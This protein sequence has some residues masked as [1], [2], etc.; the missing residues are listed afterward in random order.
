M[1][2]DQRAVIGPDAVFRVPLSW[3]YSEVSNTLYV[4]ALAANYPILKN[5]DELFTYE[6]TN[7]KLT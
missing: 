1:R 2:E 6:L 4:E 3:I 5:L 7:S